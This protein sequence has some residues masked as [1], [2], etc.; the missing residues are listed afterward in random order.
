MTYIV[1]ASKGDA[2]AVTVR[3]RVVAAIVKARTLL[4]DG[5]SVVVIGPDDVHY[6]PDAFDRL[7][8][9]IDS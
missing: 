5:W 7:L 4:D 3:L 8:S 6:P 9:C 2:V 1:R